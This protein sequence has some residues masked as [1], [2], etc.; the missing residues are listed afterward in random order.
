MIPC[1]HEP[2]NPDSCHLC[3]LYENDPGYRALWDGNPM[4]LLSQGP[5]QTRSLPCIF[6]GEVI[7][8]LDCP[9]PGKWLRTCALHK[10]CTLTV[11]KKCE[12]YQV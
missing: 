3:W 7:D 8:K 9:C 12:D 6:L 10:I 2:R 4:P 5:S 11:C 1:R